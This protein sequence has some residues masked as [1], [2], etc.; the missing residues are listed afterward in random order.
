MDS[1]ARKLQNDDA[2]S[3]DEGVFKLLAQAEQRL[4]KPVDEDGPKRASKVDMC[5]F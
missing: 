5:V 1:T 3:I 2:R 4:R